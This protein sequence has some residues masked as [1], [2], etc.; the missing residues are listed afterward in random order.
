MNIDKSP[1]VIKKIFDNIANYYDSMNNIISLGT[2]KLIKK[3][4]IKILNISDKSSVLDLCTGT[5]DLV[6]IIQK[7]RPKAKITAVDLVK[8]C[9]ILHENKLKRLSL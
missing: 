2:D 3:H 7:L 9:L 1:K 5:G 8:I 6:K 4:C